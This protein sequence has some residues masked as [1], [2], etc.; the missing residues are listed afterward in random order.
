LVLFWIPTF[1]FFF[2][3][4]GFCR[5]YFA[6]AVRDAPKTKFKANTKTASSIN[7]VT[8]NSSG[9]GLKHDLLSLQ[10]E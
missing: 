2:F 4:F 6:K 7:T 8:V 9:S 1:F 10:G 5:F 3:F